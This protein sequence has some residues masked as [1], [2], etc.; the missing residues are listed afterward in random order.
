MF[1]MAKSVAS[2]GKSESFEI[3][4]IDQMT[5][6][7]KAVENV[8]NGQYQLKSAFNSKLDKFR[9]EFM[10]SIDEKLK[11][12]ITIIASNIPQEPEENILEISKELINTLNESCGCSR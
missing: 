1:K 12:D 2:N 4:M 11:P 6:I 3:K 7:V 5:I 8:Q 9:N 10:S